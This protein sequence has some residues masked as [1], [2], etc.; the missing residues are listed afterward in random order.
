VHVVSGKAPVA[1]RVEIA[2]SEMIGQSEFDPRDAV[3]HFARHE[4]ET[5]ARRFVIEQN[6]GY[7][8]QLVTLTVVDGDVVAE[9][10]GH[11]VWAARIERRHLRLW[12][13]THPPVH[14]TR[15]CLVETN[16]RIHLP[17]GLER[18]GDTLRVVLA[19]EHR[20]VP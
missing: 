18:T 19:C 20:L 16:L 1:A 9:H 17:N 14:F 13:F 11:A 12:H 10:L 4:L 3:A 5:A 2:E 7:R 6:P 8:E 15:R